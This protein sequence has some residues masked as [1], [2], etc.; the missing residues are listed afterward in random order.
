MKFREQFQGVRDVRLRL[1]LKKSLVPALAKTRGG[2]HDKLGVG[3]EGNRTVARKIEAVRRG[4]VCADIIRA[5]LDVDQIGQPAVV[6]GHAFE[7]FPIDPFFINAQAAPARFVAKNLMGKL[8]DAGAGFTG[9]GVAGDEPTTA[10]LIA[11][12]T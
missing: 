8:V 1:A 5:N 7:R 2:V 10:E 11:L 12:P 4:P 9:T 3:A 6:V